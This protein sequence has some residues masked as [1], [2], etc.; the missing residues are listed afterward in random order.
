MIM[1][2]CAV[3]QISHDQSFEKTKYEKHAQ[4]NQKYTDSRANFTYCYPH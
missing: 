4:T 1:L 2:S 3:P